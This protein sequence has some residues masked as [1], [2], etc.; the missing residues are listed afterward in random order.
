VPGGA[1]ESTLAALRRQ[2]FG[3]HSVEVVVVRLWPGGSP[4]RSA[5]APGETRFIDVAGCSQSAAA[6]AGLAAARGPVMLLL[7]AGDVPDADDLL[8]RH[9]NAHAGAPAAV[10]GALRYE[11]PLRDPVRRGWVGRFP[12]GAP[13]PPLRHISLN[14]EA[15]ARAGGLDE[16]L[17]DLDVA[18]V[19]LLWR[20]RCAGAEVNVRPEMEVRTP[21]LEWAAGLRRAAEAGHSARAL[22]EL[23]ADRGAP[24][25]LLG[26]AHARVV[27]RWLEPVLRTLTVTASARRRRL[28]T[29]AHRAAFARGLGRLPPPLEPLA[30][31]GLQPV[32]DPSQRPAVSIVV[33]FAG[34]AA[35]GEALLDALEATQRRAGDEVIVVDNSRTPVIPPRPGIRVLRADGEWSSYHARNVGAR[36]AAADWILF[37]D[38]DCRPAP[39]LLDA[40]FTPPPSDDAGAVAGEVLGTPRPETWAQR[41]SDMTGPLSQA[42]SLGRPAHPYAVTANL[43]VRRAAL[44]EFGGFSEGV[45]S[46]ADKDFCRRLATAGWSIDYRPRAALVH[47]HRTTMRGLLHQNMRYGAGVA[48]IDRRYPGRRS[49][50]PKFTRAL[51][52]EPLLDLAA[53]RIEL[54]LTRLTELAIT[55]AGWVGAFLPNRPA[56]AAEPAPAAAVAF[57]SA[58][59]DADRIDM[60]ERVAAIDRSVAIEARRRPVRFAAAGRDVDV[61]YAEDDAPLDRLAALRWLLRLPGGR[62]AVAAAAVH[63][64]R[65]LQVLGAEA[66]VARRVAARGAT[67]LIQLD[68]DPGAVAALARTSDLLGIAAAPGRRAANAPAADG[69]A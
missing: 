36:T 67:Q 1:I 21:S 37:L 28:G 40:Y 56:D 45:R 25:R 41:F 52:G 23:L 69:S 42:R 14:R 33:P 19:D 43:L 38:A 50:W 13:A 6:N 17:P 55:T 48:W 2:R 32:G 65:A 27:L 66:A 24:V 64:R 47:L 60:L 4:S 22:A 61:R 10:V 57:A 11:P 16:R 51:L 63:G 68:S 12:D 59:P 58:H 5:D 20:L 18:L 44:E 15:I 53:G 29:L 46:G 3:A 54:M 34:G 7:V 49:D 35:D 9:A 31:G 26:P 8:V 39:W 62:G 30:R